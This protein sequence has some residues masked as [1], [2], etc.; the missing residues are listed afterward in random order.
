M[1]PWAEIHRPFGA[2]PFGPQTATLNRYRWNSGLN[3]T[4]SC[5][6]QKTSQTALVL[7]P[8]SPGLTLDSSAGGNLAGA[9]ESVRE[10]VTIPFRTAVT[11]N[12]KSSHPLTRNTPQPATAAKLLLTPVLLRQY[13]FHR[14]NE[15]ASRESMVG[16]GRLSSCSVYSLPTMIDRSISFSGRKCC[17]FDLE[18]KGEIDFCAMACWAK[19][20]DGP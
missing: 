10:I 2:T 9:A 12:R 16:A 7:A 1:K 19:A 14:S 6:S 4:T 17:K 8:F 13:N 11:K 18:R 3:P 15:P 20:G 5:W